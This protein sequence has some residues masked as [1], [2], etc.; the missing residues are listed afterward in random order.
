MK[1]QLDVDL[2]VLLVYQQKETSSFRRRNGED[3]I[4]AM[5]GFRNTIKFFL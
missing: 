5:D 2:N 1:N 4:V 3:N